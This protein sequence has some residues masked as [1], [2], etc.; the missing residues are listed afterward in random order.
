MT[1]GKVTIIDGGIGRELERRGAPFKQPEWSASA[2]IEAPWIVKEVHKAFIASGASVITTNSYALVPF[3]LGEQQFKKQCRTL[4][5]I[6]G[7]TARAAVN[8]TRSDTRPP[9]R[10]AGSIPP[11]FGSYRA[12]L[13]RPDRVVEIATPLI[14]GLSPYVDLWL[15]ETQSLIDEP[16]RI[17]SL[18]H[19]LDMSSKPFWVS[20]TLDDLHLNRE[21]M[22]RSGE[23]LVDAIK[24]MVNAKVDAVLFNCCQPEVIGQ[25]IQITKR[26]LA[27]LGAGNI[28]IG[29]YANA[30]P[31]QTEDA[32]ANE[33]LNDIRADL[34]PSSYLSWAQ[35]WVQDGATLIGGCCGIGPEHIAVLSKFAQTLDIDPDVNKMV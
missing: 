35:K 26:Q 19:H 2:M 17:K 32:K 31:P 25:A 4:A 22:L 7:K 29:A 13:Y 5:T 6:A 12:D 18:T 3:H 28:E 10:V 11:L 24:E 27:R 8:E 14:E 33:K 15:C 23:S 16:V 34:T 20:F 1:K 9:T 30:F 21:P